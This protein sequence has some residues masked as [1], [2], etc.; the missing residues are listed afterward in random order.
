MSSGV[1]QKLPSTETK[2]AGVQD[3]F[4]TFARTTSEYSAR[5]IGYSSLLKNFAITTINSCL[6]FK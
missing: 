2:D 4:A 5:K 3:E 1:V 6:K